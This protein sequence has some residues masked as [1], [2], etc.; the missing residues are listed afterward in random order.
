MNTNLAPGTRNAEPLFAAELTDPD[1]T[2]TIV[3]F[4]EG[5]E[6]HVNPG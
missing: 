3:V 1:W 2:S 6:L 5:V 4:T